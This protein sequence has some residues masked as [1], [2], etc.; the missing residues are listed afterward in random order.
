MS[1]D[2]SDLDLDLRKSK[3][4]DTEGAWEELLRDLNARRELGKAQYG[5]S[6]VV[7][8]E[9]YHDWD[10]HAYEEILD[11]AYYFKCRIIEKRNKHANT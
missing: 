9:A 5:V 4:V 1:T 3:V 8:P 6:Q 7:G 2:S 11:L 10:Q